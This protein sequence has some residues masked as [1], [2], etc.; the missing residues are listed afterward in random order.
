VQRKPI[1]TRLQ[2]ASGCS[3][4]KKPTRLTAVIRMS[5]AATVTSTSTPNEAATTMPRTAVG[6]IA[7][8]KLTATNAASTQATK[9]SVPL[10]LIP[11]KTEYFMVFNF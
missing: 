3:R 4:A 5:R 6:S 10:Q 8:G 11:M 7:I 9:M 1:V 2:V